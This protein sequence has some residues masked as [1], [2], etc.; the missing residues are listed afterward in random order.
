LNCL[1]YQ[2]THH[3]KHTTSIDNGFADETT[4]TKSVAYRD[5]NIF[6]FILGHDES[7]IIVDTIGSY[8]RQ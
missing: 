6:K 4:A 7:Y 5:Y 1:R 8:V 3:I 2:A